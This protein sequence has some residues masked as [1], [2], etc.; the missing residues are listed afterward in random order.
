MARRRASSEPTSAD[1]KIVT[2]A[3]KRFKRC[4]DWEST[5]RSN[6]LAD[7]RFVNG[8]SR[9]LWQ[10]EDSIRQAR[11]SDNKPMLTINKTRQHCLNILNDARQNKSAIKIIPTGDQATYESAKIYE[12]VV[13]H[14]EYISDA[15]SAYQ[16]GLKYAVQ[17][18]IG[19]WRV[20]TDFLDDDSFDQEIFIRRIRDPFTVYLD[21]D[22]REKDGSDASFGFVFDDMAHDQFKAQHPGNDEVVGSEALTGQDDFDGGW[23]DK[24]RVRVCEYF[25][26]VPKKDQLVAY[27]M[28][29]SQ[30]QP[31]SGVAKRSEMDAELLKIAI[32]HP[33]TKTRSIIDTEVEWFLIAGN[34][35]ID[36]RPWL[37]KYIPIVRIIGEETIIEG[38]LDRKG[39]VRALLDPQ[40]MYNYSASGQVEFGGVQSKIP[41]VGAAQAI[42]GYE[43]YWRNANV[44]NFSILPYNH[45]DVNGDPIPAPTRMQPP[46]PSQA[47]QTTM[48]NAAEDMRLVS[49]QYQ[50]DMGAP[51]NETSGVAIQQR[52]R[53]GDTATYH[54]VDEQGSSIK[55]TG[56][57]LI[58]LIPRVYDTTR[59]KK[60]MGEDGS[61]TIVKIDPQAPQALQ[62]KQT[63]RD[64]FQAI[65]NPSV[66]KYEVESDIGPAFA[67]R[68]QEAFNAFS[69]IATGNHELMMLIGDLMFKN[70]DFPGAEEIAER[71]RR[72][73][74]PQVTGEGPNPQMVQLQQQIEGLTK[75]LDATT[76]KLADKARAEQI[77][78][79]QKVIDASKVGV[80]AY[81]AQTKRLSALKDALIS[82]PEHVV[83][84]VRQMVAE[85]RETPL[86]QAPVLPA[87]VEPQPAM[88]PEPMA[89]PMP[90]QMAQ[91]G[92]EQQMPPMGQPMPEQPPAGGFEGAEPIPGPDEPEG[93]Q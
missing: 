57:I 62:Q 39:H 81:D 32:D 53:Q 27:E 93:Q 51:G 16:H 48:L 82:D 90:P 72:M 76:Q 68:R 26:C 60:I 84:L 11:A 45:M 29:D 49:G 65:F 2:E 46:V 7:L 15:Q 69:Q 35:I 40:R 89:Q 3:K 1:D 74:P 66:G 4:Q 85:A 10:W 23:L 21:P 75:L 41:F 42:E 50:A 88:A 77:D 71:L 19:Y 31:V 6:G 80:S 86:P 78:E 58:D 28:M 91:D 70:A 54:Y 79:Q 25:R 8:D 44:E 56:K 43:T 63:G 64:Q 47:Y 61:E 92:Q 18:G 22:I 17:A 30:G 37:G 20:V 38:K 87:P 14:I 36:R 52:Q 83:M 34:K 67:T 55:F 9:N 24:E 13:R 12:G 73:L 59:V 5:A 33:A